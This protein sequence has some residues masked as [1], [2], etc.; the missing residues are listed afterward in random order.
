VR[1]IN[2][3]SPDADAVVQ[4]F[5]PGDLGGLAL[6][7]VLFGAAVPSGKL[8]VS[9]PRSVGTAPAFYNYWKGARPL[10]AGRVF[11]NG[12]LMFGHEYVL[13][14]PV[15]IWSFGHGLSYVPFN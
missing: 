2:V 8:P 15:P 9:F 11:D 3:L 6:A 13:D 12:T 10:D 14:S 7:E 5:Y 1:L 4:Q